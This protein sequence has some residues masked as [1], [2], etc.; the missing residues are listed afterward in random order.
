MASPQPF[1]H[2]TGYQGVSWY[3][4]SPTCNRS[5]LVAALRAAAI[6]LFL[7]GIL[8]FVVVL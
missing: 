8:V 6:A 5:Y 4:P 7:L 1:E 3:A 2:G